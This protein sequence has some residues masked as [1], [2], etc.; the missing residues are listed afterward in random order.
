MVIHIIVISQIYVICVS[1]SH[2]ES[3]HMFS[4]WASL[5][6]SLDRAI[7]AAERIYIKP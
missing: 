7:R 1:P 5:L 4:D 3:L 6:T 2:P